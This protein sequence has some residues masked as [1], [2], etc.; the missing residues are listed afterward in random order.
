MEDDKLLGER[1]FDAIENGAVG[2]MQWLQRQ[3]K[4]DPA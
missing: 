3:A 2:S 1:M 4:D